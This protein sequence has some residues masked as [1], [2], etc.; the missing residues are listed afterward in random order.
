MERARAAADGRSA[1]TVHGGHAR[2]LRQTVVA[3]RADTTLQEHHSTREA[4]L[5]ALAVTRA[6]LAAWAAAGT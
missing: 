6:V 3:L 5:Q 1:Q 2:A 4:R